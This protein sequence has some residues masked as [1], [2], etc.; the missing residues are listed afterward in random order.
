MTEL[1]A[2]QSPSRL[3]AALDF[4]RANIDDMGRD[5]GYQLEYR[6]VVPAHYPGPLE[7][8]LVTPAWQMQLGETGQVDGVYGNERGYTRFQHSQQVLFQIHL[9]AR[10]DALGH[11]DVITPVL[12]ARQDLHAAMMLD[13]TQGATVCTTWYTDSGTPTYWRAGPSE[14]LG[15]TFVETYTLDWAHLTGNMGGSPAP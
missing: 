14:T 5:T 13:R 6:G 12:L 2:K 10:L 1:A 3:I 11:E 8:D 9:T 4:V 7:E 15:I